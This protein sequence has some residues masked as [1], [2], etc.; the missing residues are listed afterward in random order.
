M[1]DY[2]F[3]NCTSQHWWYYTSLFNFIVM[4]AVITTLLARQLKLSFW[5]AIIEKHYTTADRTLTNETILLKCFITS[6]PSPLVFFFDSSIISAAAAVVFVILL[7]I[8]IDCVV[9]ACDDDNN[10][11]FCLPIHRCRKHSTTTI[12]LLLHRQY[13]ER[14]G[15]NRSCML[16]R[17][18]R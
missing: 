1:A 18:L 14:V 7:Y 5:V 6:S 3:K 10:G 13:A 4:I 12:Q 8:I 16:I 2:S 15:G 17:V 11:G 9:V